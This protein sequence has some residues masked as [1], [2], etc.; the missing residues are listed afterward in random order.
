MLITRTSQITKSNSSM[1]LDI[2]YEQL[3]RINNRFQTKELIQNIVPNL[4]MEEREFLIT[5]IT[6]KEWNELFNPIED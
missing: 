1:E 4:S 2:T 6:P 3:D 5:G